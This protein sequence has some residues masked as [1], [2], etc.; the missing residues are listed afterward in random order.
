MYISEAIEAESYKSCQ[1][2]EGQLAYSIVKGKHFV[3]F[4]TFEVVS[5]LKFLAMPLCL[6]VSTCT[7]KMEKEGDNRNIVITG[8]S[9]TLATCA[10]L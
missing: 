7:G 4:S 3:K 8:V 2:I 6:L 1:S 9:V 10:C 5:S